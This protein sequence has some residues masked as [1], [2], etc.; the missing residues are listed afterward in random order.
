AAAAVT[1]RGSTSADAAPRDVDPTPGDATPGD[2]APPSAVTT[3]LRPV[4][5]D[6]EDPDTT[7]AV[8]D[9]NRTQWAERAATYGGTRNSLFTALVG[10]LLRE[11]GYPMSPDGTRICIAVSNRSD[12]DDRANASG[13]VWIRVPGPIGPAVG[14]TDIRALSKA[15]FAKYAATDDSVYHHL[16]SVARLLPDRVLGKMMKSIAGPDTTVSNLGTAPPSALELGDQ[17][18]ES[19]AIRA[20]MQGRSAQDR[21]SQGPALAAWAVEYDDKVTITFFGI[22]P[23]YAG[24]TETLRALVSAELTRWS[25]DHSFW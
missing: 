20:I 8:V 24:D 16:Q 19:F 11:T 7:L 10:G 9:L 25:L 4:G 21:R 23:D 1:T 15:A 6:S 5:A 22:H 17:V 18:A 2:A 3:V 14:L 13:G 12:G